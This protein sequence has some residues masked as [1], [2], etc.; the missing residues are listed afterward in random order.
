MLEVL[1]EVTLFGADRG[2]LEKPVNNGLRPS[3]NY[4]GEL[5]ACEVWADDVEGLVPIDQTLRARIKLPYGDELGWK[6]GGGESFKLN[7]ASHVIGEG[8][9][10]AV[11]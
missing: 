7:I 4:A 2:G 8:L 1:A 10:I 3:F 5:V 11:E 9:I 6:M